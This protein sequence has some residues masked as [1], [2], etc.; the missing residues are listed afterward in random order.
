MSGLSIPR[1]ASLTFSSYDRFLT[2][3][4][5]R[6]TKLK[7]YHLCPQCGQL[8]PHPHYF[9]DHEYLHSRLVVPAPDRA[10]VIAAALERAIQ[11]RDK[12][13][14]NHQIYAQDY[15]QRAKSALL[16]FLES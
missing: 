11:E 14:H 16:Q 9:E 6:F 12:I 4:Y 1:R 8:G 2:L 3:W 10:D 13:I 15:N 7:C 5:C